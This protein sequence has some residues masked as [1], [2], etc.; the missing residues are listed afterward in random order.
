MSEQDDKNKI[1]DNQDPQGKGQE[2]VEEENEN[3]HPNQQLE[4]REEKEVR[5]Y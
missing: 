1:M 2:I 3:Q 4:K 5:F